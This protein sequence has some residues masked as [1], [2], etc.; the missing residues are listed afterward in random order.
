[1]FEHLVT[2]TRSY[3]RFKQDPIP[4]S[5][6]RHLV[7]LARL[8]ASG[9]NIQ[10]LKYILS[11]DAET[12]AKIFPTTMWAGYL[13]DWP[14]PSEGERPMAYIVIL[15]D[16]DIRK[17]AGFDPGIAAQTIALGA[18]EK[19]IGACMIGSIKRGEL[20]Q[21]LSIPERYEIALVLALGAPGET[22]VLE[23][24][25]ADGDIKYYRDENDVHHVPKRRLEDI[26][27]KCF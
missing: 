2:R 16:T 17:D 6:L 12:N 25:K 20:R 15:I 14:G 13:T 26:I 18:M 27:L 1:M 7:E 11:C 22:V 19:G 21:A 10:P 8:T 3:R 4:M 5:T 23:D 24:V 9:G